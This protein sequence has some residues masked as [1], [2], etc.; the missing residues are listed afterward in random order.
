MDPGHDMVFEDRAD[1]GRRLADHVTHL[2]DEHPVVLALPRGGVVVG[3]EIARALGAP[4][5]VIVARKLGAPGH[6]ELGIGAVAPGGVRVLY[7][8][9]IAA[10]G[11]SSEWIERVTARETDE[12]ER[13]LRLYRG[14][15]PLPALEDRTVILVDDGLATGVT[16]RAAM[17]SIRRQRPR[18]LV[19]A[20]PVC[21]AET[22]A[23]L[24]PLADE[25]ICAQTPH[26]FRAVGLWYHDFTQV[27]D[28]EVI[29]LLERAAEER[30]A[31]A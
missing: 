22:A 6:E 13:R 12:M 5:N 25:F 21:A 3:Y 18:R 14:D 1:A 9:A 4:L 24:R 31:A 7:D 19:V 2:G 27:T 11:I 10:L 20:I 26:G 15:R 16:A 23:V 29:A 28:E 8:D 17:E 30:L